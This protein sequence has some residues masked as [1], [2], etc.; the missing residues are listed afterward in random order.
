MTMWINR[1][2]PAPVD[3]KSQFSRDGVILNVQMKDLA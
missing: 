1:S 3:K 2:G